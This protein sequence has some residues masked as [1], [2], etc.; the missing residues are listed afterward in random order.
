M[1]LFL[2]IL[3]CTPSLSLSIRRNTKEERKEK[4]KDIYVWVLS[5]NNI[6]DAL[7]LCIS[8]CSKKIDI[9]SYSHVLKLFICVIYYPVVI[10]CF[11]FS[12][13]S[14]Y[15]RLICPIWI[16]LKISHGKPE[17]STT[18]TNIITSKPR[19]PYLPLF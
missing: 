17:L 8:V 10:S 18:I 19:G 6:A 2:P 1:R 9:F 7:N 15:P 11:Y 3:N 4:K 14:P 13:Y 5:V 16:P 12:F